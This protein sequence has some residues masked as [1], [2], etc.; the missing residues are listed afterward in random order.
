MA[1]NQFLDFWF[2]QRDLTVAADGL[3]LLHK[4]T[5]KHVLPSRFLPQ[6]PSF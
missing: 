5:M 2:Y 6:Y 1:I 3:K 4:Y